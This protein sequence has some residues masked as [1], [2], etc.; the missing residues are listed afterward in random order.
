MDIESA[1]VQIMAWHQ[2]GAKP[3]PDP[4]M[5][6]FTDVYVPYQA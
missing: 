2:I 3:L 5:I 1:L 6:Q 4:M